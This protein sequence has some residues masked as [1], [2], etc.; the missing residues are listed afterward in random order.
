MSFFQ[1]ISEDQFQA[2]GDF[3][4]K[5]SKTMRLVI[6][7]LLLAISIYMIKSSVVIG[8][9][10]AIAAIAS[11]IASTKDRVIMTISKRGFFYYGSLLT[12]WK[13]F[14]SAEFIDEAPTIS[15]SSTGF[16][17]KFSLF[18]KYHKDDQPGCFGRKIPLT[19]TQDKSE[20]EILAAIRFYYRN[21]TIV[22]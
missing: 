9:V 11:F 15:S 16:S 18:I 1:K 4:V 8:I 5:E 21:S 20:E 7:L 3:V 2:E 13:N 10:I 6:G 12:N 19:N 22:R 14:V 17:D